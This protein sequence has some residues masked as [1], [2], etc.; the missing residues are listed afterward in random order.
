M[1]PVFN[2]RKLRAWLEP[3]SH[4]QRVAFALSCISRGGDDEFQ[5][6]TLDRAWAFVGGS[7]QP[8]DDSRLAD[9][10]AVS[11]L[12]RALAS[13]S[14]DHVI[15]IAA[16]TAEAAESLAALDL[17]LSDAAPEV[18]PRIAGHPLVQQEL[19]RQR[20]D[21]KLLQRIDL[22]EP[23]ALPALRAAWRDRRSDREG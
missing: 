13:G 14:L 12:Y 19:Q 17:G 20:D 16:M 10:G 8:A 18:D 4:R 2:E 7:G 6:R 1:E 23:D 21:I 22:D 11:L 15:A 5:S 9:T 3:L